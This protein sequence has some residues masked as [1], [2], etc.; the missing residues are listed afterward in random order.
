M[1]ITCQVQ[2]I[3]PLSQIKYPSADVMKSMGARTVIAVDVG[4]VEETNLY[5]YG[6][7]LNGFWILWNKWNPWAQPVRVLNMEEIQVGFEIIH[8]FN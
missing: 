3:V 4:S 5:N 1:S 8:C 2:T 7:S 6:D